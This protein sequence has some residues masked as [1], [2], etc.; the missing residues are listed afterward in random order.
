MATHPDVLQLISILDEEGFGALAGEVLTELNLGRE[1][2]TFHGQTELF[3]DTAEVTEKSEIIRQPIAEE[4]QFEAAM[5]ILRARLVAPVR[6]FAEA[7]RIA[8]ELAEVPP[9]G[10]RFVDPRTG[11]ATQ[12]DLGVSFGDARLAEKLDELLGRLPTMRVPPEATSN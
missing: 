5:E 11:E 9:L 2:E 1:V 3:A 12:P 6:A 7:E 10:I 8:A 4:E